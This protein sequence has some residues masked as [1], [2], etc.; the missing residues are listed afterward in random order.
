[1]DK[2]KCVDKLIQNYGGGTKYRKK[3]NIETRKNIEVQFF[4]QKNIEAK[5]KI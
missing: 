5:N 4:I 2:Q 3:F 1:M